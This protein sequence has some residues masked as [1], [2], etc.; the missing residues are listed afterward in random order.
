MTAALRLIAVLWLAGLSLAA[1]AQNPASTGQSASAPAQ[2]SETSNSATAPQPDRAPSNAAPLSAED[3]MARVAANQDRSDAQRGEY[4]YHQR[5]HI[6]IQKANGTRMRDETGDYMVT[7]TADG[8]KKELIDVQ[9][10]YRQ[11]GRYIEF[12]GKPVPDEDGIDGSMLQGFRDD[13]MNDK[14]KDGLASDLF[15]LTTEAQK[16]YRFQLVSQ[17]IVHGRPT[18]RLRFSPKDSS[19]I[20]W[21]GETDIDVADFEP[22]RVYTKLSRPIP[23]LIRKFLVDLPGVGFNVEYQRQPD[24]VWFPSS[25]GTE[26]RLR[27]LMMFA[28][29]I[30]ISMSNS[31]FERAH[32]EHSVQFEGEAPAAKPD[33]I[34]GSLS[35]SPAAPSPH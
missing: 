10:H 9:G 7:P 29:N 19:D 16:S 2:A 23:F 3:I 17:E 11:K 22:V 6:T 20:D 21:A 26:F 1:E 18:Y 25:F 24:G 4:L 35:D 12:H 8:T 13:L 28:R 34:A 30:I 31:D 5:V 33:N 14:S 27:V 15:P 32:V